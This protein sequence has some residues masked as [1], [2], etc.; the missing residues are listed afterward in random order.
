[1]VP[2]QLLQVDQ[3][4]SCCHLP[5]LNQNEEIVTMSFHKDYTIH[6]YKVSMNLAWVCAFAETNEITGAG[7][8]QC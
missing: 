5:C 3:G 7:S 8:P 6:Q 4:G 2:S 1:M